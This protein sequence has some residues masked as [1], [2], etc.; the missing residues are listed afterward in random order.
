MFHCYEKMESSTNGLGV[1]PKQVMK[2]KWVVLEKIHGA[3][4][5]FV[6]NG[7]N[8]KAAKRTGF[9]DENFFGV[10]ASGLIESLQKP[11]LKAYQAI[12]KENPNIDTVTIFGELF[13]GLYK[14]SDVPA[15]EGVH[16]V[17]VEIQYCPQL[18]FKAYD[19]LVS[20]PSLPPD[21]LDYDK[22]ME[23]LGDAGIDYIT[24]Y[25][26][27]TMEQ[28]LHFDID[29]DTKIPKSFGLPQLPF[30][31]KVEGVVVK[32]LHNAWTGKNRVIVKIKN[33]EFLET[34]LQEYRREKLIKGKKAMNSEEQEEK[35]ENDDDENE[36]VIPHGK[37]KDKEKGKGKQK[38]QEK[39]RDDK[40]R[41]LAPLKTELDLLI[42]KNR[43]I[44]T[45][46]KVGRIAPD[47]NGKNKGKI[48]EN[49]D[50]N[51]TKVQEILVS[52][53][54][55]E[56]RGQFPELFQTLKGAD[57]DRLRNWVRSKVQDLIRDYLN[58]SSKS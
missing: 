5:S 45:I 30:R 11:C 54:F 23:V 15:V 27:G 22:V 21:Y 17:Q 1:L 49:L 44:N 9:L 12:I 37:E 53:I 42:T 20:G 58:Q 40:E 29:I 19:I 32:P 10:Q 28:A 4:F 16:F 39:D 31:N 57:Q 41:L 43:L 52:E 25:L 2:D 38:E 51:K 3:N 55:N 46:S 26:I 18:A 24:P 48:S 34:K 13:G 8:V 14:H 50:N 56:T 33:V 36:A 6:I 47:K 35:R 7:N